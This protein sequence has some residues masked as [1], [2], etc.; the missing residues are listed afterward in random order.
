MPKKKKKFSPPEVAIIG[1][2]S[3]GPTSTS[4]V[5]LSRYH[6]M[7]CDEC[8]Y[9]TTKNITNSGSCPKCYDNWVRKN[10]PQMHEVAAPPIAA[11]PQPKPALKRGLRYAK[12]VHEPINPLFR[13]IRFEDDGT[14]DKLHVHFKTPTL[15]H[16][17]L[18]VREN[19]DPAQGG[20][21][22]SREQPH[23]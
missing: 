8:G 18:I 13:I 2:T 16:V 7:R 23:L 12:V 21:V 9:E 4:T 17:Q 3:H 6:H 19:P 15:R 22:I 10:V 20:W 5:M 11:P 14:E 1:E